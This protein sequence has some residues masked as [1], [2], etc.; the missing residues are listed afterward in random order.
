MPGAGTRDI[1]GC[2]RSHVL[3]VCVLCLGGGPDVA[4]EAAETSSSG[5]DST[6]ASPGASGHSTSGTAEPASE[7][8][9]TTGEAPAPSP[10]ATTDPGS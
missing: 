4:V 8:G 3:F 1:V 7:T 5:A 10:S 2:M 6:D 9:A